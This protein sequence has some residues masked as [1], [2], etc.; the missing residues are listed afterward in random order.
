MGGRKFCGWVG[1]RF[2]NKGSLGGWEWKGYPYSMR[3]FL[4]NESGTFFHDRGSLWV[5]VLEFKYGGCK[6]MN[7]GE[8]KSHE[9]IWWRD[10]KLVCGGD[11]GGWFDNLVEWKIGDG[12][13]IR[14]WEDCWIGSKYLQQYFPR[15]FL[16]SE[17]KG[18][19]IKKHELGTFSGLVEKDWSVWKR[20]LEEEF[21]NM[22]VNVNISTHGEDSWLWVV[23]IVLGTLF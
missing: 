16:T 13:Y 8:I 6:G 5:R 11:Y 22:V 18:G 2:V 10:L 3:H 14:F 7:E 1:V 21:H 15:L 23:I 4:Q 20:S 17:Q 12:R 9:S 19:V